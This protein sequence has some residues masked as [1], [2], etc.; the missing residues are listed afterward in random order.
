L[1]LEVLL[2]QNKVRELV[3]A[4]DFMA[5]HTDS[6]RDRFSYYFEYTRSAKIAKARKKF[7]KLDVVVVQQIKADR[8]VRAQDLRQMLPVVCNKEK[9]LRSY[10]QK[11]LSLE[12][13]F[14]RAESE[15][16]GHKPSRKLKEFRNW[17]ALPGIQKELVESQGNIRKEIVYEV[18]KLRTQLDRLFKKLDG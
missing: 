3:N 14:G 2:S 15:G 8:I 10:V 17:L 4:Y 1:A 5:K 9:V 12:E 11:E 6:K 7:D 16:G 18:G 13:A